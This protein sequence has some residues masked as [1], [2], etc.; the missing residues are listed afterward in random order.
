MQPCWVVFPLRQAE[1]REKDASIAVKDAEMA[2]VRS[3]AAAIQAGT[4]VD[5]QVSAKDGIIAERDAQLAAQA[6]EIRQRDDTIQ[7]CSCVRMQCA[8]LWVM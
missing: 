2:T 3:N 5:A 6:E 1:V 8:A 4:P 7:V